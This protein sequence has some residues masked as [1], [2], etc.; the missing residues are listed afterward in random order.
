VEFSPDGKHVVMAGFGPVST[1][2]PVRIWNV[3]A[4]NAAVQTHSINFPTRAVRY[5]PDGR[6]LAIAGTSSRSP[7]SASSQSEQLIAGS[8]RSSVRARS[9][10]DHTGHPRLSSNCHT[11]AD[12]AS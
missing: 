3:R 2:F 5:S 6:Y 8:R 12:I 7:P 10:L 11:S 1:T 4:T 9:S